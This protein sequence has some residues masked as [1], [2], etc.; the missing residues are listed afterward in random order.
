[1]TSHNTNDSQNPWED[2]PGHHGGF[3]NQTHNSYHA[4]EDQTRAQPH[5]SPYQP[6]SPPQ[7]TSPYQPTTT[8][9]YQESAHHEYQPPNHPPPNFQAAYSSPTQTQTQPHQTPFQNTPD[10]APPAH[11]APHQTPT[12]GSG[13]EDNERPPTLPPRRS[14]TD[15]ALPTGHD[16]T[17]QIEVMQSY[18]ASGR[19]DEHDF[20]VE[21]LQREFPKIDGSLIAAIYGDSK[22]LS[23]TREMLGELGG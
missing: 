9:S 22:S 3:Q 12:Y 19:R 18:E 23:A 4:Y 11:N 1:M 10:Y 15:L 13:F 17:H 2:E 16:R 5:T 20:N 14:A 8:P 7:Q 6:T 21:I